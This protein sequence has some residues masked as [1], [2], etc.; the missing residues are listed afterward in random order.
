MKLEESLNTETD[1]S[2]SPFT[3]H[4]TGDFPACVTSRLRMKVIRVAVNH[5]SPSDNFIHRKPTRFHGQ[6]CVSL[7]GQQRWQVACMFRICLTGWIIMA[8]RFGKVIPGAAFS[9]MNMEPKDSCFAFPWQTGDPRLNQYASVFL[10]NRTHPDNCSASTPPKIFATA[11]GRFLQYP[12][13]SP[14]IRLCSSIPSV[15]QI[16]LLPHYGI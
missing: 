8:S 11:S 6:I 14:H 10:I 1:S 4:P 3:D 13:G 12:I 7:S 5:H 15:Q 9:L 16:N 2:L